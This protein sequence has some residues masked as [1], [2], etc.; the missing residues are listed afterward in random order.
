M[1]TSPSGKIN[2]KLVIPGNTDTEM[3]HNGMGPAEVTR[4]DDKEHAKDTAAVMGG[5][6]LLAGTDCRLAAVIGRRNW[7]G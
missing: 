5:F 3:R 6:I 4:M 7:D 2:Q 1:A